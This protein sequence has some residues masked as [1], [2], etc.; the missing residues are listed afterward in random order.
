[1]TISRS[2]CVAANGII[3][4]SFKSEYYPTIYRFHIFFHSSVDGPLDCFGVVAVV[5]SAAVNTVGVHMV[6]TILNHGFLLLYLPKSG[7]IVERF[8]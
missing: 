6:K 3:L 8:L 1:M 2:I 5:N 4:L 7:F